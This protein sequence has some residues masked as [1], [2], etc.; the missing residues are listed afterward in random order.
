MTHSPVVKT[1]SRNIRV[2]CVWIKQ[3]Y[4]KERAAIMHYK[5]GNISFS[6]VM[7]EW[8]HVT[9]GQILSHVL[10]MGAARKKM[11][12]VPAKRMKEPAPDLREPAWLE[13]V[14]KSYVIWGGGAKRVFGEPGG[15][16]LPRHPRWRCSLVLTAGRCLLVLTA[17]YICIYSTIAWNYAFCLV[18][19]F[20]F[21][22]VHLPRYLLLNIR[23]G[24]AVI[25]AIISGSR[26]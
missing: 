4:K 8:A 6:M 13:Y 5:I 3:Q 26:E 11:R 7:H 24:G 10:T 19:C 9:S 1:C 25:L 21:I 16:K 20:F 22:G 17:A 23:L 2:V 18:L 12:G 14:I 15:A